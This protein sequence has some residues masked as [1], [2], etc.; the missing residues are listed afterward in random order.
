[1]VIGAVGYAW[2]NGGVSASSAAASSSGGGGVPATSAQVDAW[3]Y[4]ADQ[5]LAANGISMSTA[6]NDDV[7]III[8]YESA[9][10]PASINRTDINARQGNPSQGLMQTTGS[11][12]A[13][14]CAPGYCAS[15][16]DPVSNIVAGV[17][18][19]IHKYGSLDNVPGVRSIH[20]GGGYKPY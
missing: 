7:K 11:T 8:H 9:G 13:D 1:M 19:A 12:F 16:T 20:A 15:I 5:V 10:N 17:R 14:N 18:Y 3:I 6:A 2:A 4:Q